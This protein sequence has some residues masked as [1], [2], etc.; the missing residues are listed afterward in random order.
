MSVEKLERVLWRVRKNNPNERYITNI[1]LRRAIMYECGTCEAT[2]QSN[3]R[4]LKQLRWIT[5][6][7]KT[8]IELT[9]RDLH[10]T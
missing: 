3:R 6:K 8:R 4:A 5:C 2:Y 1:Q 7:G 9:G 10:E